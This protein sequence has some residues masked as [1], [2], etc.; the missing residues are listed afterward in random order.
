M[1]SGSFG[2]CVGRI[3]GVGCRFVECA[4]L[5]ERAK[6]FVGRNLQKSK[7]FFFAD[8]QL[9]PKF[10]GCFEQD[11]CPYDIG[12][13][14]NFRSFDRTVDMRFCRKID[15]A[16]GLVFAEEFFDKRRIA[17][18]ALHKGME[19]VVRSLCQ[20]I[21]VPGISQAI[22][23]DHMYILFAHEFLHKATANEPR[24]T[25]DQNFIHARST[26]KSLRHHTSQQPR[27]LGQYLLLEGIEQF[28]SLADFG[29]LAFWLFGNFSFDREWPLV[30][31]FFEHSQ[32]GCHI[33]IALA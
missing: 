19:P 29:A 15:D 25:G 17:D 28:D 9:I 33:D 8:R 30:A 5:S 11:R 32:V 10:A 24:A 6:N 3:G 20:G 18:V 14:E 22:E 31:D 4:V 12:L 27:D 7:P 23:I 1:I 26:E 16:A 2:S 21:E 13:H